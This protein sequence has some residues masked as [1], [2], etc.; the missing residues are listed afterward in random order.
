MIRRLLL[1]VAVVLGVGLTATSC[2]TFDKDRVARIGNATLSRDEFEEM[3]SSPLSEAALQIH[4]DKGALNGEAARSFVTQWAITKL[5]AEMVGSKLDTKA[6]VDALAQQF[7]EQWTA[8]PEHLRTLIAENAALYGMV[9]TGTFDRAAFTE[10][11]SAAKVAVDPRIGTWDS[12]A[13][14]VVAVG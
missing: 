1:A 5:A 3:V 13:F 12:E 7:G 9:Q 11:L 14:K 4:A 10:K 2:S 8:A 6:T